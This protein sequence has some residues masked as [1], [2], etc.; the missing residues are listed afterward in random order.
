MLLLYLFAIIFYRITFSVYSKN[1]GY[2]NYMDWDINSIGLYYISGLTV[3][4]TLEL[5]FD[6][7]PPD[8]CYELHNISQCSHAPLFAEDYIKEAS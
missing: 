4:K 8:H 2:V 5:G 6:M 7:I 3:T 1:G